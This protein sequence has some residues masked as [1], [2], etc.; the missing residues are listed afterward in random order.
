VGRKRRATR[1]PNEPKPNS[2]HIPDAVRREVFTR[3]G[4]RCTFVST[5]GR[6]CAE[7]G[8]LELHHEQPFGR[9]GPATAENIRLMCQ[10][11]NR[12]LA[13]RD[14]GRSFIQQRIERAQRTRDLLAPGPA[15]REALNVR[16]GEQ[17]ALSSP[18]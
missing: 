2:R 17:S 1:R 15:S 11:H 12:L 3:D 16:C 18:G 6:R 8:R 9:G 14:Y 5:D 10:A 7:R 4:A 13:E